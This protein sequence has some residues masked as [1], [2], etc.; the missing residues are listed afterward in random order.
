MKPIRF[1][2]YCLSALAGASG[3]LV[4]VGPL[5]S[6]VYHNLAHTSFSYSEDELFRSAVITLLSL[7]LLI[8]VHLGHRLAGAFEVGLPKRPAKEFPKDKLIV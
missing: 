2:L 6:Y 1:L 3:F 8:L 5:A 4:G 7:A